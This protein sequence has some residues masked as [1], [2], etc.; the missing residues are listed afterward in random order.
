MRQCALKLQDTALLAKLSGGDLIAQEA[1]YHRKCL[2]SLYNRARDTKDTDELENNQERVHHGLALASLLS[3]IEDVRADE[4][5]A[6]I[7]KM[8]D[9]VSLYSERLKQ[10]GT[11]VEHRIHATKLKNRILAHFP[12][13]EA[14][15]QG[16]DVVLVC[17]QDVGKALAKACEHDADDEAVHLARA[18]KII[19]RDMFKMKAK[20]CGHFDEDCQEMSVPDSLVAL[21]SMMLMGPNIKTQTSCTSVPQ[22]VLTISQLVMFNSTIRRR[23]NAT[24]SRHSSDRQPPL[25]IYLGMMFHAKE[26]NREFVDRMFNLGL[27][28]SY[29]QVLNI[30]NGLGNAV[31]SYYERCCMPA[32]A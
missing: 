21:V 30:S 24:S 23:T 8:A 5:V 15:K 14:H 6:P 10:L 3:Y 11:H 20:F 2:A 29:D 28:I 27:S 7:F 16:R 18:A 31:C 1:K 22:S 19:R 9:L 25:P 12:D 17:N 26:R 4:L 32:T 13:M